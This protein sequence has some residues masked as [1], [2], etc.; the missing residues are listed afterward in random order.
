MGVYDNDIWEKL[1]AE[2]SEDFVSG[3]N[4]YLKPIEL[5][6]NSTTVKKHDL[7]F[8]DEYDL[9]QL[10]DFESIPNVIKYVLV[11]KFSDFGH[12][13]KVI[14]ITWTNEPIYRLNLSAPLILNEETVIDYVKF[15]FHYVRGRHGRFLLVEHVDDVNWKE[16]PPPTARK[17]ITE[18]VEPIQIIKKDEN[19]K[20]TL[21]CNMVFKDSLFKSNV[22]VD[23][24]GKVS[25]HDEEILVEGMPVILDNMD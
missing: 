16:T 13:Q 12:S 19:H 18:I 15:F 10:T 14:P 23:D 5:G 20:F 8:Y 21:R 7:S 3:V 24:E 25:L 6:K 2:E 17:A 22:L 9:F 1:S 11:N 4:P